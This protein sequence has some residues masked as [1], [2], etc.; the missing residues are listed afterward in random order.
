MCTRFD[1]Y[2]PLN[3]NGHAN[4]NIKRLEP[5]EIIS[6]FQKNRKIA[7]IV[8]GWI[9]I[10]LGMYERH[11]ITSVALHVTIPRPLQILRLRNLEPALVL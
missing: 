4:S 11:K 2:F 7:L 6:G 5:V 9:D 1:P 8:L 3:P 10:G